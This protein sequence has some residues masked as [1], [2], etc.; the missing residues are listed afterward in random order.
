MDVATIIKQLLDFG[1]LGFSLYLNFMYWRALQDRNDQLIETLREVA[2]LRAQL[3]R[4]D[5]G[6]YFP[7]VN[8][9]GAEPVE[10]PLKKD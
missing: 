9:D 8:P 5:S 2:G 7:T 6:V 3:V 4:R 1:F 10:K